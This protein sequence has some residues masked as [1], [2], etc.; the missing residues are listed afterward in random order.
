MAPEQVRREL[1]DRRADVFSLG[2]VL[3]ELLTDVKPFRGESL[4][5]IRD[6]VLN[7]EPPLANKIDPAVRRRS[8]PSQRGR[9]PRIPS[10]ASAR[11]ARSRASCASGWTRIRPARTA[12]RL[13]RSSRRPSGA[14]AWCSAP[15]VAAGV[16]A[17]MAA[18]ATWFVLMPTAPAL[19]DAGAT[20]SEARSTRAATD[21]ATPMPARPTDAARD[22]GGRA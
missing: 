5:Q 1:S 7:H 22:D 17:V 3:Y 16:A 6:A 13:R 18:V 10:T 15:A 8:P 20:L 2:V 9:W 4:A 14:A 11:R 19:A 21:V 12:R